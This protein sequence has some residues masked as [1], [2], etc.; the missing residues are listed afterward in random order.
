MANKYELDSIKEWELLTNNEFV[1]YL[2]D[3]FNENKLTV[4]SVR[5]N[6]F[7]VVEWETVNFTDIYNSWDNLY[8][9]DSSNIFDIIIDLI[10]GDSK[11]FFE[12]TYWQFMVIIDYTHWTNTF[13]AQEDGIK[14][15][16]KINY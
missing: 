6:L 3:T 11:E 16:Y 15:I 2:K 5:W 8:I 4:Y 1:K 14:C 9:N 7:D 12:P 10:S 13:L